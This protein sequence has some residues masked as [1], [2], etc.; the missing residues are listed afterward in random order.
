M[1]LKSNTLVAIVGI[2]ISFLLTLW[3]FPWDAIFQPEV[4]LSCIPSLLLYSSLLFFLVNL[5]RRS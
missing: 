2:S 4:Q 5:Y 1:K 3:R